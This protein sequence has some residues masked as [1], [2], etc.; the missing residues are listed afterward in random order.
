[1]AGRAP[2]VAHWPAKGHLVAPHLAREVDDLSLGVAEA[3]VADVGREPGDDGDGRPHEAAR[4]AVRRVVNGQARRQRTRTALVWLP[5]EAQW[6]RPKG[7]A[8]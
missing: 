7:Q 6:R 1:M 3:D 2:E 4:V 5:F 8:H